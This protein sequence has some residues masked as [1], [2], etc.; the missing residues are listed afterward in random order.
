MLQKSKETKAPRI[1]AFLFAAALVA[2]CCGSFNAEEVR[3]DRAARQWLHAWTEKYTWNQ[4]FDWKVVDNSRFSSTEGLLRD[5]AFVQL[6]RKQV[7]V[8][9]GEDFQAKTAGS[10]PYLLRGVG[11]GREK[12]PLELYVSTRGD[13]GVW[14]GGGANN[15]CDVPM[16]RRAV[17]A[18]LEK[19]R[20]A[21]FVTFVVGR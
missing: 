5:S 16:E 14:V 1:A 4:I 17:V 12:F 2:G 13:A 11:D 7:S 6:S 3:R 20:S 19:P 21:V 18:W 10:S 8:L 9:L 15:P